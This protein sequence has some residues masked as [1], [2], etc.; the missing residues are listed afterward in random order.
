VKDVYRYETHQNLLALNI[1][2]V[3]V[4]S[5]VM[6]NNTNPPEQGGKRQAGRPKKQRICNR[7][8]FANPEESTIVCSLCK[9]RGHNAKTCKAWQAAKNN[10]NYEINLGKVIMEPDEAKEET[11]DAVDEQTDEEDETL[12]ADEKLA[13][14]TNDEQTIFQNKETTLRAASV[15]EETECDTDKEFDLP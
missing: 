1:N 8:K 9:E 3:V 15:N 11:K 12:F 7:S 5:L 10:N 6:D 4:D 2:P 14:V 13:S